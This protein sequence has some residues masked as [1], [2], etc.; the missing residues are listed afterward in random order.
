MPNN[1]LFNTDVVAKNV[2]LSHLS[3]ATKRAPMESKE[4][5]DKAIS[6]IDN[7]NQSPIFKYRRT[8]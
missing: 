4:D 6:S 8:V 2:A 1:P 5:L 3:S 7:V